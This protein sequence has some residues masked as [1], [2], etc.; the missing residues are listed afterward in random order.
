MLHS[1]I[2]TPAVSWLLCSNI[3]N[4]QFRLAINS[5]LNQTFKNFELVIVVNGKNCDEVYSSVNS[6]CGDDSRVRILKTKAYGLTFSLNLG[7]QYARSDLIARMDADDI[8]LPN[9]LERQVSYMQQNP[10]V[11]VLGSSY[12]VISHDGQVI[13]RVSLPESNEEIRRAMKWRNPICHPSVIFRQSEILNCG[14]YLGYIYAEDY[15][16][17]LQLFMNSN[18][19][20]YNSKDPFIQYREFGVG[21]ARKSVLAYAS[22]AASQLKISIIRRDISWGIA[23]L[24]SVVK[25]FIRISYGPIR[26]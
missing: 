2:T 10:N 19:V 14:G 20:F 3:A 24:V 17:W 1:S 16:L 13:R 4:E 26:K 11:T 9:R 22:M 15:D 18:I 21:E 12:D 6:W 7:L 8:S 25:S 23:A 5:C